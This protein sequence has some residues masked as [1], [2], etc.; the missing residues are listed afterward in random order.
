LGEFIKFT[1]RLLRKGS[2]HGR[3]VRGG[4]TISGVPSPT[5]I[6]TE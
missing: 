6:H 1:P 4:L 2:W 5:F 3:A